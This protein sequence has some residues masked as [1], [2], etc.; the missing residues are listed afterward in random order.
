MSKIFFDFLNLL[1]FIDDSKKLFF[2]KVLTNEEKSN[3]IGAVKI[4][5]DE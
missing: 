3:K 5:R 1:F 2:S 4:V